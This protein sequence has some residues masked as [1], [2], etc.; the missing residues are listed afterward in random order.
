MIRIIG[1]KY[2]HRMIDQPSLEVTR[3]TKDA[4]KEGVFSSINEKINNSIFLDLFS[5]SG[6]VG[7][8][9]ISRGAKEVYFNDTN[10]E[11]YSTIK[12]NLKSLGIE[13]NNVLNKDYLDALYYLKQKKVRFNI[14]FLDPPYKEY[15]FYDILKLLNNYNLLFDKHIIIYEIDKEMEFN[16]LD[17]YK[18]KKYKYGKT[19]VYI[20]RKEIIWILQFIQEV[21][22][23]LQMD[24]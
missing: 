19:H 8:E 13:N 6:S 24:I 11:A 12:N 17:M 3:C 15:I 18:I 16:D 9:A 21:L 23:L 10:K 1:G 2:R 7:I 20:F 5:G 4:V 14:V 22:I